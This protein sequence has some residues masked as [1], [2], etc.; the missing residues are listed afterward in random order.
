LKRDLKKATG[1]TPFP[2]S[3]PLGEGVD[4]VLNAV[5]Q[6]LG[7]E[8]EAKEEAAAEDRPWSPL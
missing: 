1:T 7:A 4:S 2:V 3:A 6:R 8:V 5:I